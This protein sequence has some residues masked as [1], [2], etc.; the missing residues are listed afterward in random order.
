MKNLY[1][2]ELSHISYDAIIIGSGMGGLTTAACLA[3]AG[4]K[5][6]VLEKHYVSGGF[7]QTF[8]R[9]KFEWDVGV[10]YVGQVN[11]PKSLI[12]KA[13]DYISDGKLT[14]DDMG[15][16]Y[17]QTTIDGDVYDFKKGITQQINQMLEY[18]PN[19]EKAIRAYYA[20]ILQVSKHASLFFIEKT[21]PQW[22]SF[23]FG[24][25][26]RKRFL[27][28]SK[29]TTHEVLSQLTQ[30][31]KL[32]A[33]LCSQCGNYG[34]TPKESSFGIHA[35]VVAHYL[36]GAAYPSGGSANI[37]KSV[38]SVIEKHQGITALK[39]G[40]KEII[41][42]NNT[43]IGV[44]ME[45]GDQIFAKTI[46]SNVGAH[47]TFNHLIATQNQKSINTDELNKIPPSVANV[48]LYVGLNGSDQEL[49]FPKHNL[50]LYNNYQLD[51]SNLNHQ[52]IKHSISP[53][54]YI[55]FPSAKDSLWNE[56]C[57][58]TSTIQVLGSYS[59]KWVHEW[60]GL[61][62]QKRGDDYDAIKDSIKTQYLNKLYEVL[63]QVKGRVEIAELSTPLSTKHFTSYE[64]GEIYGLAHSPKRFELKQLRPK[65][66]YKNLYLTGQDIISVGVSSAM[67]AGVFTS[68]SILNRNILWRIMRYKTAN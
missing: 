18:F 64:H 40:V 44:V 36:E 45:N 41:I 39:A 47:N 10:H 2:S 1:S 56:K 42:K 58:G 35:V 48:C 34:L 53:V 21:M 8:K 15:E 52:N 65:T 33:V 62:W 66:N 30:N 14:W 31:Q 5:V 26:L 37:H 13:F 49:Q 25:Q 28:Y 16:V 43:A 17:D 7:T 20:L 54:I 6:L 23:L 22:L 29:L 11:N 63:P 12:R 61:Q 59:Y 38:A 32:I 68:I 51:D 50:W 57:P 60:E 24:N 3:K 4:K 55:S 46:V 9:K 19:D 67:I 27:K